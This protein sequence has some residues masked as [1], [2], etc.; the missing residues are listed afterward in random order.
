VSRA[1]GNMAR[2]A[3]AGRTGPTGRA[4]SAGQPGAAL[5]GVSDLLRA[6]HFA[7][8]KHRD[9]RRKGTVAAPYIN[10]PIAVA[11]QLAAAGF[12]DDTGLLMAA[13]LHD[14]VEDTDTTKEELARDFGARVAAI[15]MEVTD[16]KS[17][18]RSER[19]ERVV[20]TI[21]GKSREAR[22]LKLSDLIANVHDVIHHPPHWTDEQKRDYLAWGEDVAGA[23]SGTH[24]GLEARL[25]KLLQHARAVIG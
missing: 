14:V 13:V 11:E 17:L 19:R 24:A 12:Q 18:R 10:H 16:D 6:I 23:I 15:V 22:L 1:T 20:R 7:A 9:H 8:E 25:A 4:R 5:P 3:P 2:P 21:A